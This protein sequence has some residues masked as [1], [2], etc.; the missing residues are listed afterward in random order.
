MRTKLETFFWEELHRL[1]K[2][3]MDERDGWCQDKVYEILCRAHQLPADQK[4][5]MTEAQKQA[6]AQSMSAA[7]G[8][9]T[10]G[11]QNGW[12]SPQLRE[13]MSGTDIMKLQAEPIRFPGREETSHR[14]AEQILLSFITPKELESYQKAAQSRSNFKEYVLNDPTLGISVRITFSEGKK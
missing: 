11:Q 2:M 8:A 7:L 9:T 3:A 14:L 6:A 10:W 5:P 13:A 1:L 12:P 4:S